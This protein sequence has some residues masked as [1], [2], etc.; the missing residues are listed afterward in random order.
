MDAVVDAVD[1]V[2][3]VVV[4]VVVAAA[5]VVVDGG[6]IVVACW[7]QLHKIQPWAWPR[8]LEVGLKL[9]PSPPCAQGCP[10]LTVWKQCSSVC[11]S[12]RLS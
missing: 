11:S 12:T 4:V 8:L 9:V 1:V 5:V 10:L 6:D 2:V 3:V 7:V